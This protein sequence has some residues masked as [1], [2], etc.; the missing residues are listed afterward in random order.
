MNITKEEVIKRVNNNDYDWFYN[1]YD[2][3][4]WGDNDGEV[5]VVYDQ[6]WGDGNDYFL[7]FKFVNHNFFVQ[8]EG[9]YSS[10]DSPYWSDVSFAK[11]FDYTE[12]RYK[13]MSLSDIREQKIDDVLD[14]NDD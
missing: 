4:S 9:T 10:W 8:L 5:E 2:K 11:P 14:K 13:A 6:N 3:Y 7:A 12:T 1:L